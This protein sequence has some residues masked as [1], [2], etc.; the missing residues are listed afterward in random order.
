MIKASKGI[1]IAAI[2][3]LSW[4]AIGIWNSCLITYQDHNQNKSPVSPYL[5]GIKEAN[6]LIEKSKQVQKE[7]AEAD[8][9]KAAK[10]EELCTTVGC[11]ANEYATRMAHEEA[12]QQLRDRGL[13]TKADRDS[14]KVHEET[15]HKL[16]DRSIR[17]GTIS[18]A[19]YDAYKT[20]N[21][22]KE[23]RKPLTFSDEFAAEIAL[24][25]IPASDI[26]FN[27]KPV[28]KR[29]DPF[30]D[31]VKTKVIAKKRVDIPDADVGIS[32]VKKRVD[33]FAEVMPYQNT[34]KTRH[35]K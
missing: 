25:L 21:P 9:K 13:K 23:I 7:S 30:L 29:V 3:G 31:I 16:R 18:K 1:E 6:R 32:S 17:T 34:P 5:E 33:P 8:A 22:K 28:E 12:I 11:Q 10:P 20:A 26:E 19:D 27:T 2:I 14:L 35:S 15:V 24:G 4:L